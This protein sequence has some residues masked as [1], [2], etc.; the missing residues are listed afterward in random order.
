MMSN[1]QL[2]LPAAEIRKLWFKSTSDRYDVLISDAVFRF[3][4]IIRL[5]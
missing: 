4:L 3:G 2:K 5:E 1:A